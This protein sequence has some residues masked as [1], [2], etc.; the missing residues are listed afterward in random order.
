MRHF[1]ALTDYLPTIILTYSYNTTGRRQIQL[2][3][4]GIVAQKSLPLL[5]Q[6]K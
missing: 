6:V 1:T 3:Q 2:C 4:N 5:L